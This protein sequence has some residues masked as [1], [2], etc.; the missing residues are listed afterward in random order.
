M[1]T[2]FVKVER[3]AQLLCWIP[4]DC[5]GVPNKVVCCCYFGVDAD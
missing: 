2:S 5:I 4:F 1:K 3:V